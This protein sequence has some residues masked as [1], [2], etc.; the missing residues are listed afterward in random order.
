M[1]SSCRCLHDRELEGLSTTVRHP[2]PT[3]QEDKVTQRL[4]KFKVPSVSHRAKA[5]AVRDPNPTMMNSCAS[6]LSLLDALLSSMAA[7]CFTP[8]RLDGHTINGSV[9]T[10]RNRSGEDSVPPTPDH[11]DGGKRTASDYAPPAP[12]MMKKRQFTTLFSGGGDD[13]LD[14]EGVVQKLRFEI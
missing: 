12:L 9:K 3:R 13:G 5:R 2:S 14:G 1:Q 8:H 6:T 10:I 7:L 4:H 11:G